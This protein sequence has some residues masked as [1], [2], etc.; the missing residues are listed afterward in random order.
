[1][2]EAPHPPPRPASPPLWP[3]PDETDRPCG[4]S[5]SGRLP[6]CENKGPP[7]DGFWPHERPPA[8]PSPHSPPAIKMRA[9]SWAGGGGKHQHTPH[10]PACLVVLENNNKGTDA[11]ARPLAA[12]WP[13]CWMMGKMHRRPWRLCA[14]PPNPPQVSHATRCVERANARRRLLRVLTS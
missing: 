7:G 3:L 6:P 11:N 1:M 10:P 2:E 8:P 14:S 5:A 9:A 4:R 12:R 13:Q